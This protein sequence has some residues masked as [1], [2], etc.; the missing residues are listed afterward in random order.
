M[1]TARHPPPP[2]VLGER[3]RAALGPAHL[4]AHGGRRRAAPDPVR[5]HARDGA[6]SAARLRRAPHRRPLAELGRQADARHGRAARHETGPTRC[7]SS[8][9]GPGRSIYQVKDRE[10]TDAALAWLRGAALER[11]ARGL[12]FCATV[13]YMMPHAPYVVDDAAY[14]RYAGRV[15][16]PRLPRPPSRRARLPPLVARVPGRHQRRPRDDRSGRAPPT[17]P[18]C[19]AWTR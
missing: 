6:R 1:L 8:A 18:W 5:A 15:P 2:G 9:S 10:V 14:A 7:R 17:G 11:R 16:P 19:T 4:G 13:G 12:P 3:R